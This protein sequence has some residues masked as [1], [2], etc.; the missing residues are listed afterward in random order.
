VT[1]NIEKHRLGLK[2]DIMKELQNGKTNC[3]SF[4]VGG[5]NFENFGR[6]K[7]NTNFN[8]IFT[9]IAMN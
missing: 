6:M 7:Y 2:V 4:G 9:L 8:P 3:I 5:D 1:L